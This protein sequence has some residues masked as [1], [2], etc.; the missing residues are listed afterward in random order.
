MLG[1]I[2]NGHLNSAIDELLPWAY[3]DVD[4]LSAPWPDNTAYD[5]T[6]LQGG[7]S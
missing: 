2:V 1:R 6:S 3:A 7:Q 5:E 4:P